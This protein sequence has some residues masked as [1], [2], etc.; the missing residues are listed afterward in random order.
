MM[1][2]IRNEAQL[3]VALRHFRKRKNLS[4]FEVAS[5]AGV[6]QATVSKAETGSEKTQFSTIVNLMIALDL[7]LV[8]QPRMK[9][10]IEE[11]IEKM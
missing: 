10:S 5:D 2:Y 11:Y 4:Q 6:R 3:G 1:V 7:E 9:G 8:M